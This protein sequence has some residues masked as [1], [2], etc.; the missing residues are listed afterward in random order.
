MFTGAQ[1]S[2]SS[3]ESGFH[4][5]TDPSNLMHLQTTNHAMSTTGPASRA[6]RTRLT[7]SQKE[8][9][10]RDFHRVL[11]TSICSVISTALQERYATSRP[12]RNTSN[13]FFNHSITL[14]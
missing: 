6:S 14:W 8:E 5:F 9:V 1:W 13:R 4:S 10:L 11:S 7:L 2:S 12:K 3:V